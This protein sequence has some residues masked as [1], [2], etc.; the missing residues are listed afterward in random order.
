MNLSD[1]L[2]SLRGRDVMKNSVAEGEVE[3]VLGIDAGVGKPGGKVLPLLPRLAEGFFRG[4]DTE[5]CFDVEMAT[6]ERGRGSRSTTE[7]EDV[8]G[9]KGPF[10]ESLPQPEDAPLREEVLGLAAQPEAAFEGG[11]VVLGKGVEF[12]FVILRILRF[13]P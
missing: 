6:E 9:R 12:G 4:I 3:C 1:A 7:I 8:G 5:K 10:R 2:R 13:H 11:I